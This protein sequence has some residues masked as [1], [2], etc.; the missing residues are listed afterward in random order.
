MGRTD[1]GVPK[2]AALAAP[3]LTV[4]VTMRMADAP[5]VVKMVILDLNA[6]KVR[7]SSRVIRCYRANVLKEIKSFCYCRCHSFFCVLGIKTNFWWCIRSH[8]S[9]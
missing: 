5:L 8:V 7:T 4:P 6:M 9:A 3:G 2:A 1:Q